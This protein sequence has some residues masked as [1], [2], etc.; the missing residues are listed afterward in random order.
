MPSEAGHEIAVGEPVAVL[1]EV[2]VAVVD[3]VILEDESEDEA[4]LE[5]LPLEMVEDEEPSMSSFAPQ[6]PGIFATAPTAFLR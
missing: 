2:V 6:I 3:A 4:V 5:I 1:K